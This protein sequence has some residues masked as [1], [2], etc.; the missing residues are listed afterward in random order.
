MGPEETESTIGTETRRLAELLTGLK[1]R[2]GRSYESLA[3]RVGT[4]SSALHRYCNGD[5]V[6]GDFG[7][8]E[9][10]ARACG[11]GREELLEVHRQWILADAERER[12][13]A[14]GAEAQQRPAEAAEAAEAA[15]PDSGGAASSGDTAGEG[16][17]E[18]SSA[19]EEA[20]ASVSGGAEATAGEPSRRTR[21]RRS[22]IGALVVITALIATVAV[23]VT[24]PE[25][26]GDPPAEID[27]LLLSSACPVV[28]S[29]GQHDRCVLELQNLL[30]EAGTTLSQD[31]DFGPRTLMR[32]TAF[33]VLAGLP[34][35]GVVDEA[36]K[37]AL[38]EGGVDMRSW[39][40][41]RIE[42]RIREVFPEDPDRAVGIA[43]CQSYL[44][45]LWILPNSNTTRNWGLFQ[46]SDS[47]LLQLGGTP[48]QALDP[49]WNITAARRLWSTTRSFDHWP[50]DQAFQTGPSASPSQSPGSGA[51]SASETPRT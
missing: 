24:R 4:S 33:Q 26:G 32:V 9:R 17:G 30:A 42:Q 14:R 37:R 19:E 13:R 49:E 28:I 50:C 46:I 25:R 12:R 5:A 10:F 21:R 48:R 40:A 7:T 36:T 3:R 43:R 29:M 20:A 15:P 2:S 23:V 18:G 34:A 38:Y 39:D 1:N 51:P 35:N 41:A 6:P 8:V 45:P 16:D 27:R 22:V 44:D 31:S 47:R 11:A